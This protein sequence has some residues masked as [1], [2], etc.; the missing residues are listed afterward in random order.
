MPRSPTVA[1][2][3]PG[4]TP[5]V[6]LTPIP[7]AI[8]NGAMDDIYQIFN[9]PQPIEY[10]GTNAAT[11]AAARTNLGLAIG[12]DVPSYSSVFGYATTAT[13][14]GTTTLTASSAPT[15]YF[16]GTTTQT[17][18][19]PV[20]STLVL[21]QQFRVVNN[22]TGRV[23]VQSSG[24]NTIQAM[25]GTGIT[26]APGAPGTELVLTCIAITGTG[27][28]SWDYQYEVPTTA[29]VSYTPT[30]TNFGTVT[31]ISAWS[32]R[33]GD[34]LQIRAKFTTGTTVVA[35]ASM[36]LGFNGTDLNVTSDAT[37]VPSIQVAGVG[38]LSI[39]A[40]TGLF[41]LIESAATALAFG[42]QSGTTAG[43]TKLTGSQ[44][45]NGTIVSITADIPISGW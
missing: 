13:A 39:N 31:G 8:W 41:T 28:A 23:T 9:T 18:V 20:V 16:T 24:A 40:A 30:F 29:W 35:Q 33:V 26:F 17:V 22:S 10:G 37:K 2:Q 7:S 32:R 19:L 36:S 21:G 27:T 38:V 44:F 34:T 15:Q 12:T 11:A 25:G 1:T 6:P 5:Q 42:F 43:L 45:G 3:P 4:T 14:A